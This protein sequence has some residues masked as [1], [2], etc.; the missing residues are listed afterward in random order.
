MRVSNPWAP[1]ITGI[2]ANVATLTTRDYANAVYNAAKFDIPKDWNAKSIAIAFWGT[3]A[4]D[5]AVTAILWG[6]MRTNGPIIKMWAG[7]VTLGAL[8]V[9]NDP[10]T[11]AAVTAAY[12]ADT[13]TLTTNVEGLADATIRNEAIGDDIAFLFIDLYGIVDLYMEITTINTAATINAIVCGI[14]DKSSEPIT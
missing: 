11:K 1:L 13:I 5:E 2:A 7:A 14:T 10:I 8:A 6:R 12:W 9:T 3:N 4:E